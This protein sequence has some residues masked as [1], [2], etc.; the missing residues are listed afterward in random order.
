VWLDGDRW[1]SELAADLYRLNTMTARS[2][3]GQVTGMLG[4]EFDD[5]FLADY[6]AKNA[7]VAAESINRATREEVAAVLGREDPKAEVSAVYER[8]VEVRAPEIAETHVTNAANFGAQEGAR[9]GGLK[10]KRWKVNSSNPRDDH[11]AMN[12]ETVGIRDVFSNGLRW[13]GD[14]LGGAEQTVHCMCSVE[15]LRDWPA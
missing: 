3:A 1:N 5:S 6:L 2:W 8:A 4:I 10:G 9:Q 7:Q 14:P 15:F 11:A 12:G 13:P